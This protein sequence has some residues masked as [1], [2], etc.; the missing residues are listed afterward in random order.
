[1]TCS[2]RITRTSPE[3][4]LP[5]PPHPS[6]SATAPED[7]CSNSN[8]VTRSNSSSVATATLN[9][10]SLPGPPAA[11]PPP[12]TPYVYDDSLVLLVRKATVKRKCK[13]RLT[14][15]GELKA[16]FPGLIKSSKTK[17]FT[18]DRGR[19]GLSELQYWT[20]QKKK[21]DFEDCQGSIVLDKA[22]VVVYKRSSDKNT[23]FQF[24]ITPE[25]GSSKDTVV[26]ECSSNEER[27]QWL[28]VLEDQGANVHRILKEGFLYKMAE[29]G[30]N[31]SKRYF[32]MYVDKLQ[33]YRK[34]KD[35]RA[36][37]E[38]SLSGTAELDT[39]DNVGS[40]KDAKYLFSIAEDADG[41]TR[42]FVLASDNSKVRDSWFD[43]ISI[44]I[45]IGET[46]VH[47]DSLK[48]DYM[49][50]YSDK[51]W[52]KRYVSLLNRGLRVFS[53]RNTEQDLM[54]VPLPP[55]AEVHLEAT[56]AGMQQRFHTFTV[57]PSG[58][59]GVRM[60]WFAAKDA[61][62]LEQWVK[63]IAEVQGDKSKQ[64]HENSIREGYLW[65]QNPKKRGEFHKRYMVLMKD[66]LRYY[67]RRSDEKPEGEWP[68][69]GES[70]LDVL[71][72]DN[73]QRPHSFQLADNADEDSSVHLISAQNSES[74]ESWQ[75][76]LA[77]LI[78]S[79]GFKAMTSRSI[80]EGYLYIY[81]GR[82][83]WSKR[84]FV[85]MSDVILAYEHKFDKEHEVSFPIGSGAEVRLDTSDTTGKHW[86]LNISES[87]DEGATQLMVACDEGASLMEWV[88]AVKE[89]RAMHTDD[90]MFK[91]SLREGYM[92][93]T[94]N[95]KLQKWSKRYFVLLH[96]KL[97]WYKK[98]N[99][100]LEEGDLLLPNGFIVHNV[101]DV[102]ESS[103]PL[104]I[105]AAPDGDHD[106]PRQYFSALTEDEHSSWLSAMTKLCA[107]K[108]LKMNPDSLL[109]GYLEREGGLM[110]KWNMR[111][112]ILTKGQLLYY[113]KRSD[114]Q[115]R[116]I[117]EL[118]A[119]TDIMV[120]DDDPLTMDVVTETSKTLLQAPDRATFDT[121][122][123][124]ITSIVDQIATEDDRHAAQR[125]IEKTRTSNVLA[126]QYAALGVGDE[127]VEE[128]R[129]LPYSFNDLLA[130]EAALKLYR[131]FSNEQYVAE[132]ILFYEA[133][134]DYRAA[135]E[136]K[137]CSPDE[138]LEMGFGVYSTYIKSEAEYEV[139]ISSKMR[140]AVSEVFEGKTAPVLD[141]SEF[142]RVMH[143]VKTLME[144][145]S[146]A[147]FK[148]S[149]YW[150]EVLMIRACARLGRP[151]VIREE[152]SDDES[153]SRESRG[154][155]R[156]D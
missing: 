127:Q 35:E 71:Q 23:S 29:R 73:I 146:F 6:S 62:S 124:A 94:S 25:A 123:F 142:D 104:V 38:M 91:E 10:S 111:Y 155:S 27:E 37:H 156:H 79:K 147:R 34:Q 26:L 40:G 75:D 72:S 58:D 1:M 67:A 30:S 55:A 138:I 150:R 102:V 149:R 121:W 19:T 108:R 109:E 3:L 117:I 4:T 7:S 20:S 13:F 129:K 68:V 134:R 103:R 153:A 119:D 136:A 143:E 63:A 132:N 86:V 59:E 52:R 8:S 135:V 33:Y 24:D 128:E 81:N 60:D 99:D 140:A 53:D 144:N 51:R 39:V 87:G 9:L 126:S 93:I 120:D 98:K 22:E 154:S 49:W 114:K 46:N 130:D 115:P 64:M 5:H 141:G 122:L 12:S 17:Y 101:A 54:V 36:S 77:V 84:Y 28:D 18:V 125:A 11:L 66:S 57:A 50:H 107:S 96:H 152:D 112:F 105:L 151:S 2:L 145:N 45:N 42:M 82:S 70:Q 92:Y 41:D 89:A 14:K 83:S 131:I 97:L 78:N 69:T 61:R 21:E 148:L 80:K 76:T 100:N 16:V 44:I 110:D 95:K 43:L 56:P 106:T 137:T 118:D 90:N 113:R 85:L 65:I 139:N 133:A 74:C 88:K 31:H 47:P 116:G 48:E 15:E 32:V